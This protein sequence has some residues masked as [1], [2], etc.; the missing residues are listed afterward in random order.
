[1]P[2]TRLR[3]IHKQDALDLV[4]VLGVLKP[5]APK[6]PHYIA[7]K[8]VA[9]LEMSSESPSSHERSSINPV[10]VIIILVAVGAAAWLLLHRHESIVPEPS[11]NKRERRSHMDD[12]LF[13][14]F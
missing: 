4:Y 5:F 2:T 7:K 11:E 9:S 13:Q 14:P 10:T 3:N 6:W 1:M 12:P 8:N